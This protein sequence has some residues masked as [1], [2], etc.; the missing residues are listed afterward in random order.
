MENDK[1]ET[2]WNIVE[3]GKGEKAKKKI[4]FSLEKYLNWIQD[5]GFFKKDNGGGNFIL[6]RIVDNV[7]S[8]VYKHT[9]SYF[10][11]TYL[12]S[13]PFEFDGIFRSSIINWYGNNYRKMVSE[14]V[15]DLLETR[16]IDFY[17]DNMATAKVFFENTVVCIDKDGIKMV[18]YS[19]FD[20]VIWQ[21]QIIKRK[22]KLSEFEELGDFERFLANIFGSDKKNLTSVMTAIGYLLHNYKPT[23]YAPAIVLNDKVISDNPDGGTGK[24]IFA[25]AIGHFKNGV[26]LDGKSFDFNK[27]FVF[28]RVE[29][30]TDLIVFDDVK[31]DFNFEKLFSVITE[32]ITVEKKNKGE[33]FIPFEH[34]PKILITT[35]YALKGQG[36]SIERRKL[37]F[38]LEQY[39][40]KEYTP[41][42]EF[43]KM[44]FSEWTEGEWSMFDNFMLKCIQRYLKSGLLMP[45]NENLAEKRLMA[46]TNEGFV[47]FMDNYGKSGKIVLKNSLLIDFITATNL[48][49][50]TSNRLTKWIK[51]YCDFH[52]IPVK[53]G[54]NSEGRTIKIGLTSQEEEE[55]KRI[56]E[57]QLQKKIDFN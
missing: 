33:F 38:E 54:R 45:M 1:Y 47:D 51:E 11:L 9:M 20:G 35:N 31:Q 41:Y 48:R 23:S 32:G 55:V 14:A 2:F 39:Y 21:D 46:N 25:K 50:I 13:L 36:N 40:T 52:K 16:N 12:R 28:Q 10:I 4:V 29:H 43:N 57:E 49:S 27:S 24:G 26:M 3:D 17:R 8:E 6:V 15:F 19:K 22:V 5:Q 30:F 44:F 53:D 7:V 56:R 34:S 42:D 37:D 18:P